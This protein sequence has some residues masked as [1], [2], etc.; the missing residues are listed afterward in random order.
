MDAF[1]TGS[2]HCDRSQVSRWSFSDALTLNDD[3]PESS[4]S[5]S[6]IRPSAE[7][8]AVGEARFVPSLAFDSSTK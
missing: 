6:A 8:I 1:C 4:L 2:I 5:T 3:A 7:S